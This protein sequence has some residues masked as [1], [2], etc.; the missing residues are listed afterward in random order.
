MRKLKSTSLIELEL[1]TTLIDQSII[2]AK[3]V[4]LFATE[5]HGDTSTTR[6]VRKVR[7]TLLQWYLIDN[8]ILSTHS[9]QEKPSSSAD[10]SFQEI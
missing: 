3:I 8:P 10:P 6:T 7:P 9:L 4:T 5:A 1:E 2:H